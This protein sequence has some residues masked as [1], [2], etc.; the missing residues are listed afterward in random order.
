MFKKVAVQVS[1]VSTV[2]FVSGCSNKSVDTIAVEDEANAVQIQADWYAQPEH[3]GF[4]L[5]WKKRYYEAAGIVMEV[6]AGGPNDNTRQKVAQGTVTFG[7]A[8]L[9]DVI[10]AIDRG[11]PLVAV[12]AYL[13]RIPLSLMVHADQD[14]YSVTDIGD[15]PVMA[16]AGSLYL[17]RLEA[18]HGVSLNTIPHMR[19]IARFLSDKELVQ[20]CYLTNE[21]Y[22]VEREGV[23][24]RV[25]PIYNEGLDSFRVLY[26]RTD[27]VKEDPDLIEKVV[28]ISH[29][30]WAE[31]IAEGDGYEIAHAAIKEMNPEQD[32]EF[33]KWAREQMLSHGIVTGP[34]GQVEDLRSVTRE[35]VQEM[36]DELLNLGLVSRKYL[37]DEIM[38]WE[39]VDKVLEK[40]IPSS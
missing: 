2:I 23:D 5:A 33:M 37:A 7:V 14:V 36:A 31:Y 9:E 39:V 27:L 32:L 1:I 22:F 38:A 11:L 29:R 16:S 12:G 20:Q 4:Y 15:R 25:L 3:S 40:P 10:M 26:T 35:R 21:P 6:K 18:R 8:R 17:E 28:A 13:Q 19:T 34:S 30:G 24:V